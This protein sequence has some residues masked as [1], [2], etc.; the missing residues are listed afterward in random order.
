MAHFF[1]RFKKPAAPRVI[2]FPTHIV[3]DSDRHIVVCNDSETDPV[4]EIVRKV[5]QRVAWLE[6]PAA[7]AMMAQAKV[8]QLVTPCEAEVDEFLDRLTWLNSHALEIQ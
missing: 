8:W 3:F 6:G 4:Y 7:R 1:G 5:E 2:D